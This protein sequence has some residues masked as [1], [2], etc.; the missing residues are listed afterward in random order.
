MTY[1]GWLG[2]ARPRF[3]VVDVS[4]ADLVKRDRARI[5]GGPCLPRPPPPAR[6]LRTLAYSLPLHPPTAPLS[7]PSTPP[8]FLVHVK[9]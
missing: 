8:L 1:L 7:K 5:K 9:G 4:A 3:D 2:G 6:R